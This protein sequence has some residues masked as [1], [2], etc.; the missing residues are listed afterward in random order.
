MSIQNKAGVVS[1]IITLITAFS[2][3][4]AAQTHAAIYSF[5]GQPATAATLGETRKTDV[6]KEVS[7][8][9]ES[10]NVSPGPGEEPAG[11]S[12]GQ[13]AAKGPEPLTPVTSVTSASSPAETRAETVA[14]TD[15]AATVRLVPGKTT[16]AAPQTA[17]ADEW[18]FQF[19]PYFWMASLHGTGGVGNRSAQVDM[20]FGDIFGDLKFALMGVFEARKGKFFVLTDMEYVHIEDDKATPGPFFSDVNA[21]FKTFIFEPDV[22]YRLFEN[23]DKGQSI[24]VLGG[25]RVWHVSTELDFGPGILPA[26]NIE[27]SRNWVDAVVGMRAKMALSPKLFATGK[28]DLG[29]GGSKFTWQIF[30]GGGYNITPKIAL[31]G[32]YRVLDVDY[33]KN[34]FLYDMN[35][36]GPIMGLGFKF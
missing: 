23:V 25:I 36:R 11:E 21:S 1:A 33:D 27:G 32:G 12:A 13:P 35:Q 24:D 15:T 9:A 29:G 22:G 14:A 19:S 31:I 3:N 28:F 10:P 4:T 5:A 16:T 17:A 20:S 6:K 7:Q 2:I 8:P 18:Q 34:N 30:A 26:V